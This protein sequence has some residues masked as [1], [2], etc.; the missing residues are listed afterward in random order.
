MIIQTKCGIVK[1][2]P[3]YFDFTKKHIIDSVQGSLKRLQTKYID[4]LLLH[5]PD[6]LFDPDE[7][8]SAFN[9]LYKAKK[10]KYFGVSNMNSMQIELLQSRLKHKLLFNQMQF[11]PVRS[12]MVTAGLF[13]NTKDSQSIVR[14]GSLLEYCRLKNITIQP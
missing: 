3:T 8:A 7:V 5:R 1:A 4:V 13:V 6:T 10:V 12:E 14:D 9:Y 11:N 2:G